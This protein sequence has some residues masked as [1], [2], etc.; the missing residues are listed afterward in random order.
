MGKLVGW[1]DRH[2]YALGEVSPAPPEYRANNSSRRRIAI[3][4]TVFLVG[5]ALS[6]AYAIFR[7]AEYRAA[8]RLEI[9]PGLS[10]PSEGASAGPRSALAE[11]GRKSF[12][13]EVQVLVSRP[14]LEKVVARLG[15]S[16]DVSKDL[17]TD[18]VQG[19]GRM[20]STESVEGTQVVR[21]QA[22]GTNPELLPRLVNTLTDVYREHLAAAYK[23]SVG[24]GN[25][26]LRDETHILDQQVAAKRQEVE[27]FRGRYDIVSAERDENQLLSTVKGL[28]ESLNDANTDVATAEGHLRAVRNAIAAGEV[29]GGAKN[30]PTLADIEKRGSQ[31]REQL[32]ELELRFTP[33]YLDLDPAAKALRGR[34]AN[35]DQQ[36]GSERAAGQRAAL[37]EA[38][39]QLTSAREAAERLQQ[40]LNGNK[41]AAQAFAAR[42]NEYKAMQEDLG[43]LEQLHRGAIERLAQLEASEAENAPRVEVLEAATVP[44]EPLYPPYLLAGIGA[45]ASLVLG[46]FAVRF[47][48]F[49]ARPEPA[50]LQPFWPRPLT[51][52]AVTAQRPLLTAEPMQLPA[53]DAPLRQLTDAEIAA[54]LQAANDEGRLLM[55]ALFTGL[56]VEEIL[57]LRWEGLD[58]DAGTI[59][60]P[61]RSARI[62]HLREPLR[63][64]ISARRAA[65]HP[66]PSPA[67]SADEAADLVMCAAY[68][69]G[70]SDAHEVTPAM[71][72]HTYV[73][74][75]LQQG[76]RF[77]DI[78]R[79]VGRLPQEELAAYMRLAP[80]QARIPLEQVD[81]ILPALRAMA[82]PQR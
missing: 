41:Q 81:L 4:F 80:A 61:G 82:G 13:T 59:E 18:P 42:L 34:L 49:F 27:A 12:L 71:L 53:P 45:A 19:L 39:Q 73:A 17:G 77:A 65:Q 70:L 15:N 54:L 16:D 64:L 57:G 66:T 40:Q 2:Q 9:V 28:G 76:A 43:H 63:D 37:A 33:Q 38:Q 78:G 48:E 20:L 25:T 1:S 30:N 60:V 10:S 58:L 79:I 8:A 68:D 32:H 72:R 35:L 46:I 22:Q 51:R 7:P 55:V 50:F 52:E 6:S 21:V 23:Q 69:A 24:T 75:L 62:L 31:L 3:F 14:V 26:Q 56:T 29:L 47:V 44:H 67:S 74:F 11:N 36:M 5:C